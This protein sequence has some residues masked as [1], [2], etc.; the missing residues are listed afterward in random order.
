MIFVGYWRWE[1]GR[2]IEKRTNG[3]NGMIRFEA[4]RNVMYLKLFGINNEFVSL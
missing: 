3:V 1:G 4:V 2:G